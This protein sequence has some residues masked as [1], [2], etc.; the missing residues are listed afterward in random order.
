M[1]KDEGRICACFLIRGVVHRETARMQVRL[2]DRRQRRIVYTVNIVL[3]ALPLTII[4]VEST[5]RA[6][7]RT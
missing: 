6:G 5:R 4:Y 7:Q 2:S 1:N 3:H